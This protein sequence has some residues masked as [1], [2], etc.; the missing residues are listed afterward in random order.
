MASFLSEN[1]SYPR[2]VYAWYCLG[3]ICF[4]YL[5][6]FMDRIIVSLL[7]PAIQHDLGLTDSEMGVVQGLAFA[8]FYT[9]F[10][11][12]LGW[13]ADRTSRKW[14]LTVGTT[15][16]SLMTAGCGLVR[17]FWGLFATRCGVGIGEATLNPCAVSLIGD[18]FPPAV[19]PKAF[20]VYTAS[21]AVGSGL[22]YLLGGAILAFAG[23][24]TGG[25]VFHMPL[26]GEIPA[27]QA[28]FMIIGLAGLAPVLLMMLTVREPARRDLAQGAGQRANWADTFAFLRHNWMTI[29]CHHFGVAFI[30]MG[31]YGWINWMPAF[32]AR[33]HHWPVP[34][35]SVY[36]GLFGGIT[37]V[38][39]AVSSGYMANRFRVHGYLD[40]TM[41]TVLLGGIG[42]TIC[43]SV[44]PLMPTPALALAGYVIGGL[45]V[46]YAPAQALAAI[47][48]ITPNQL[49]G[50]V[51]AIYI[52]VIGIFGAGA[53]PP[54][55]GWVTDHVFADPLK[56]N[57]SMALVTFVMGVS[58]TALIAIGLGP[59][60]GS[61]ARVTWPRD[62]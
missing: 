38:I 30:L 14:L 10:V 20:G 9:L 27:W 53:G 42:L 49:R 52:L 3:V 37:G 62:A 21:T 51:T 4:A 46:N 43:T 31:L 58:G 35:F 39:S 25:N 50:F 18:Y 56:I 5:F 40:G 22:T 32:F 61:V 54:V 45:F 8:V 1:R 12:P 48:E 36:Y 60:R 24:G 15:V 13:A 57:Y 17:S 44:A 11:L 2:P 6:G 47:A 7:T 19:R 16:W 41:R 23:V 55:M 29:S 34:T 28:V 26:L 59:F 33:V